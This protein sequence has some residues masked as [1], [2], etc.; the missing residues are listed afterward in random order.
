M[1]PASL[2]VAILVM[3]R[4][5]CARNRATAA[6]LLSRVARHTGLSAKEREVCLNLL[7][8]L[9]GEAPPAAALF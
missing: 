9:E 3:L 1:T 7:D 6:L 5:P 4:H 2:L 8:E